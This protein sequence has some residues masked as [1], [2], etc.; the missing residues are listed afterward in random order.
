VALWKSVKCGFCGA[1][2]AKTESTV[3]RDSFRQALQRAR[4]DTASLDA[5]VVGGSRYHLMEKL[6][7]GEIS[8]VYLARRVDAQPLLATVK[9][10]S[11]SQAAARYARE[12][13]ALRE[14]QLLD[15]D[16]AGAYFSRLLPEVI[17]QGVVEGDEHKQALVLRHFVGFWGSLAALNERFATGLDPRHA[18]WI[19]RRML[20]ALNF[21]HRHG[22]SHGDIRPEHALIDPKDHGVRLIGWASSKNGSRASDRAADLSRSARIVQVLL[23]GG[24]GSGDLPESVPA[25]LGKLVQRGANDRDFCQS[26]GADGLDGLLRAEAKEAFGPPAFVPLNI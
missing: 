14:L 12:A 20:E 22:W 9:L 11:T 17:S 5:V 8:Q 16:G 23:C 4:Q 18:V 21:V 2:I 1:L 26:Q 13:Q 6:G 24:D 15:A 19:W 7:A 10:S 25:G 3:T